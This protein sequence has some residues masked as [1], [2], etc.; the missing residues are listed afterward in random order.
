MAFDWNEM[1]YAIQFIRPQTMRFIS[2][3]I[4][5]NPHLCMVLLDGPVP[6]L[7]E[8]KFG[9]KTRLF[10]DVETKLK[11]FDEDSKTMAQIIVFIRLLLD[12]CYR[13]Q[14]RLNQF[15]LEVCM[16]NVEQLL[17]MNPSQVNHLAF[18]FE[19][20]NCNMPLTHTIDKELHQYMRANS[21]MQ[22]NPVDKMVL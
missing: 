8:R 12:H 20:A 6:F 17:L 15:K 18:D 16:L 22:K 1:L 19:A 13:H 5:N 21:N 9:V 3:T 14:S 7:S 4:L 2:E 11:D 10:K